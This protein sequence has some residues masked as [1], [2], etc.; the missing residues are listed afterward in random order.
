[1]TKIAPGPALT[2]EFRTSRPRTGRAPRGSRKLA[3]PRRK[4]DH[5]GGHEIVTGR[6]A[7]R[8]RPLVGGN[9]NIG[10]ARALHSEAGR[11]GSR[12]AHRTPL[13]PTCPADRRGLSRGHAGRS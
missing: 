1:A 2:P 8:P 13:G 6:R 12:D 4:R 5:V 10:P 7:R 3:L 9:G 11:Y